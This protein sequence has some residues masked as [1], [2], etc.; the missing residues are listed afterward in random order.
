MDIV[1]ILFVKEYLSDL[2]EFMIE[3]ILKRFVVYLGVINKYFGLFF[4][5][6][7]IFIVIFY[8]NY[9]KFGKL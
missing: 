5:F 1:Q 7:Q 2:G 3:G 6:K 4:L 9:I 8:N